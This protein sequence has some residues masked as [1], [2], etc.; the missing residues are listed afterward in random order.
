[1]VRRS[2]IPAD[3]FA[4]ATEDLDR[5]ALAA[6][7][8]DLYRGTADEVTVDPP[9]VSVRSEDDR[10]RL[11][12]VTDEPDATVE[13]VDA[14][15]TA[16]TDSVPGVPTVGP[17]ELRERLLYG[18]SPERADAVC[19]RHL[20]RPARSADYAPDVPVTADA[21]G[22]DPAPAGADRRQSPG[23]SEPSG[24]W[25]A[26]TPLES[27]ADRIGRP[28]AVVSVLA[29]VVLVTGA[30]AVGVGGFDSGE[31]G[32]PGPGDGVA[33]PAGDTLDTAGDGTPSPTTAADAGT[34]QEGEAD[35]PPD[36]S[37]T[38]TPTPVDDGGR[39][40]RSLGTDRYADLAPTCNRS[41]LHVV[42]IQ[43]NALGYN[44]N[45]TN[46]GIRTVRRFAS[47]RNR[48]A[49][50]SF[51]QF[52]RVIRSD[53]YAPMLSYDS[54]EY[55]GWRF[56]EETAQVRV[57]TRESGNVTARYEFRLRK[58]DGGEYDGCWMTEG[59]RPVTDGA[60][61]AAE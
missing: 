45:E 34:A 4:T 49:V 14:A 19:E 32:E 3:E 60:G 47:P 1:M 9:V 26:G 41:F 55:D 24:G 38:P 13:G 2:R 35:R 23:P 57:T 5:A 43:M 44:D 29:A 6:F 39:A 46:D 50:G 36:S 33:A 25:L 16:R 30:M 21:D 15:V 48:E 31:A 22:E 7:V 51:D 61:S 12:A 59:V 27:L 11:L 28:V 20:D 17:S 54:A 18:L 37:D 56:G 40:V 8:G 52:V 58:Q 10:V 42:Q 53:T